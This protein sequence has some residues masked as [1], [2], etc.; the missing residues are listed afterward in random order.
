MK[1][2]WQQIKEVFAGVLSQPPEDRL[3]YINQHCSGDEILR[4]EV[5][6]L[7]SSYDS[8]EMFLESPA[9]GEVADQ[10]V[11]DGPELKEGDFLNHYQIVRKIGTGGMGE[12]YL[13]EDRKLERQVAIKILNATFDGGESNLKRFFQEAKAASGLN[14][15]NIIVV[16]EIGE[17]DGMHYIV[18]EFVKGDTLNVAIKTKSLSLTQVI[19][20]SIQIV[21]ALGAAHAVGII[22]RDIKPDNIM[23]RDDGIVK[24]LDFGLAK[25]TE[26]NSREIDFEEQ[27]R[28]LLN[29]KAGMILGTAA[30]MSP[31][32][33]RGKDVDARSDIWSF[34]VVLF[35]MLT[36]RLPFPGETTSD[37]I[38]AI[39]K[40]ETP[41]LAEFVSDIPAELERIV[42]KTLRK[43]QNARYQ[44]ASELLEDLKHFRRALEFG[45]KAEPLN[46]RVINDL[47]NERITD[48]KY[49]AVTAGRTGM[50]S[51]RISSFISEAVSE[52]KARPA[53]VFLG[54]TTLAVLIV[55]AFFGLSKI[56]SISKTADAFQNMK[57]AKLTYEGG[58]ANAVTVSPDGK[59]VAYALRDE[60]RQSLMVRQVEASAAVQIVPPA[61]VNY[62][63]LTFTQDGNY[64][65]YT[66]HEA[67]NAGILYAI[68]VLGGNPRK[69][70]EDVDGNVTFSPAGD[71]IAFV[72]FRTSLMLADPKGGSQRILANASGG[73]IRTFTAWNPNGKT[74]INSVFS[75][76]DSLY[77]LNEVSVEDG[78]EKRLS[79]SRWLVIN[80]LAWLWDGSG[81]VFSG[82]DIDTQ[83]SQIWMLSYPSGE[84]KRIT[85][86]F[87]TYV[88]LSLTADNKSLLAIKKERL[89]N[90]W[91]SP[92]GAT[93]SVKKITHEE[94]KDEGTSGIDWT[95]D[96]KIVYTVRTADKNDIWI[97][98]A[99]GSGNRQLTFDQG[100]NYSPTVSPDGRFIVFTSTRAGNQNL[101]QIDIDGGNPAALTDT[102]EDEGNPSFAPDGKWI[103]YQRTNADNL[104]TIWK[105]NLDGGN[106]VQLIETESSRPTV[107]ADSKFFACDYG[108][109]KTGDPVKL[110]IFQI[111]GGRPLKVLDL[112]LV[113]KSRIF[114]WTTDGKGL[115]YV[116]SRDRTHNL[117]SQPL[118]NKPPKQLTFFESGQ[119]ARFKQDRDGKGFALSRG[120]ESSDVVMMSNFR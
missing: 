118:D 73:E 20:S 111:E 2:N 5:E 7:L 48:A 103:L 25:L 87:S 31:E 45:E 53:F 61:E 100:S 98:N 39:L 65:Y 106:P 60:G 117:W 68:P 63:G 27:T 4:R 94:G 17:S 116:N 26:R 85:N 21:N 70:A 113:V 108:E 33:A 16:Y 32:Q 71:T 95:P 109:G 107:S 42:R 120:N 6:S 74:I 28:E 40:T 38:A 56:A 12:V 77:Y 18:I 50:Y 59:Y 49:A 97:V 55:A 58:A 92:D 72:R 82:R 66:I 36:G 23:L 69:I 30:Y 81:V 1:E 37:I 84:T 52:V 46:S 99:D 44:T 88:G 11:A 47:N 114:R 93:E 115:I 29:T 80:G 101:W 83:F 104:T 19:D 34:G 86:D 96:G 91:T 9:V 35:Q 57:L 67:K 76:A 89:F 79:A 78:T 119:I 8:A 24:V 112:P 62:S 41:H 51:G 3:D 13:A 110:S 14:H 90:I 54:V 22:H 75:S 102:E 10:L 105:L 15:P 43:N 64:I